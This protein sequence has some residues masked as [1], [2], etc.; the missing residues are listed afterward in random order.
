MNMI[1]QIQVENRGI[2]NGAYCMSKRTYEDRLHMLSH[3]VAEFLKEYRDSSNNEYQLTD[4]DIDSISILVAFSI[5]KELPS[6]SLSSIERLVISAIQ[7]ILY[8]DRKN[9]SSIITSSAL[10][11]ELIVLTAILNSPLL[12]KIYEQVQNKKI[13]SSMDYPGTHALRALRSSIPEC[14]IYTDG[15]ITFLDNGSQWLCYFDIDHR[16]GVHPIAGHTVRTEEEA[17]AHYYE[18]EKKYRKQ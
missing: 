3:K 18:R 14:N 13:K 9:D 15:T 7:A 6:N 4:A 16:Y 17:V 2:V 12:Q 5:T 1:D 10:Q 11:N 8:E